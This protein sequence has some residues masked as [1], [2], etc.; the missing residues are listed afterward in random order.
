[1][2][3][4]PARG[5]SLINFMITQTNATFATN[6]I[7]LQVSITEFT[8]TFVRMIPTHTIRN[9]LPAQPINIS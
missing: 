4:Q 9:L 2:H 8:H 5:I 7:S 6:S 1:M 3:R